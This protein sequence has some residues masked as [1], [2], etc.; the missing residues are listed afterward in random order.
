MSKYWPSDTEYLIYAN[1]CN[2]M[3]KEA[4]QDDRN[5]LISL[6]HSFDPN[7]SRSLSRETLESILTSTGE[8]FSPAELDELFRYANVIPL[9]SILNYLY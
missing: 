8:P 3:R 9:L 1:F 7:N 4:R 6:F 2:I 5:T